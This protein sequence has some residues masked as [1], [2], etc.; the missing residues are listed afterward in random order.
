M[1]L[2][3]FFLS[4]IPNYMDDV[5]NNGETASFWQYSA[6]P[7]IADAD[8]GPTWF[9]FALLAFTIAYTI[10]R[11]DQPANTKHQNQAATTCLRPQQS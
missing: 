8:E 7:F 4:R 1:V 11:V 2:Y 10:W 9:L 3:T 5:V 6:R